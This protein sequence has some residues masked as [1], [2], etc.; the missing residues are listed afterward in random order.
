MSDNEDSMNHSEVL[1][2]PHTMFNSIKNQE[3]VENEGYCEKCTPFDHRCIWNEPDDSDWAP[4]NSHK[5]ELQIT[6]D[7][8]EEEAPHDKAESDWD[9]DIEQG[10][11]YW[12]RP[13]ILKQ[14]KPSQPWN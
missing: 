8:K 3:L 10:P 9:A 14:R 6:D 13:P 4:H 11:D 5:F 12:A 2:Q 1:F 7:E